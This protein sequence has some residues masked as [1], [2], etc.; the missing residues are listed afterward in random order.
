[1][2]RLMQ[3]VRFICEAL[4]AGALSGLRGRCTFISFLNTAALGHWIK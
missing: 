4:T 3:Y 1:M 2:K